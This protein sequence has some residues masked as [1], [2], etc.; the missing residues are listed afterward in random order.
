MSVLSETLQPER[1][2]TLQ[3]CLWAASNA[4]SNGL[5]KLMLCQDESCCRANTFLAAGHFWLAT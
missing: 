5:M 1:I 3:P 2:C 4:A